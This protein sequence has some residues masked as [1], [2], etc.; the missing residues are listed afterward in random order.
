MR[1]RRHMTSLSTKRLITRLPLRVVRPV[2][3]A[4]GVALVLSGCV[5]QVS[6]HGHVFSQ[7]EISQIRQG[8]SKEQVKLVLG[9]PDTRSSIGGDAYYYISSRHE[10]V[11]F[12]PSKVTDRKILAI[13]FDE[14]NATRRVAHYG[15]K[16]GKV[17]DIMSGST[18]SHG[19]ELNLIQQMFGN[20]GKRIAM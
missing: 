15:L 19:K 13:Y 16:D 10:T 5:A 20:L 17:V 7:E 9:T 2:L 6:N 14:Y 4:M 3:G 12:M 11:G 8:M 18:P 1:D